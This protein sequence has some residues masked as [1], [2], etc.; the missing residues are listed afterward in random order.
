MEGEHSRER[1]VNKDAVSGMQVRRNKGL[2][3]TE[4]VERKGK[5]RIEE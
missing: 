3:K 5:Y 1:E 4:V 2:I